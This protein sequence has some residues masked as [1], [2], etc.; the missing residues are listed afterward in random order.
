MT[1]H[2]VKCGTCGSEEVRKDAWGA[3]CVET[4]EWELDAI[5]DDD[6]CIDCDCSCT[7]IMEEI[8]DGG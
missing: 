4:Q 8:P 5:Y 2:K 7:I 1:K 6:F 3:W